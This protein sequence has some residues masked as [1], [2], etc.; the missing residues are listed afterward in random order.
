MNPITKFLTYVPALRSYM[1]AVAEFNS[2]SYERALELLDQCMR[3]PSFNNE[4]VYQH[5]GQTL[6]ALGQVYE[7]HNYLV[8][9]CDIYRTTDWRLESPQEL[10]LAEE[11]LATLRRLSEKNGLDV[12]SEILQR[13]L[14]ITRGL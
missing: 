7:G 8:K 3:H 12:D 10:H 4:V 6:C 5:Y 11:T 1:K 9:A 13:K 2:N 14:T